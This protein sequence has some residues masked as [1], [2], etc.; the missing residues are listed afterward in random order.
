M[1]NAIIEHFYTSFI[2]KL[3]VI[4]QD[5]VWDKLNDLPS[6]I[7]TFNNIE[8]LKKA[9]LYVRH[10]DRLFGKHIA[11]LF[12]SLF[13][14][15][16]LNAKCAED[17]MGKCLF[18]KQLNSRFHFFPLEKLAGFPNVPWLKGIN[19]SVNSIKKEILDIY[20]V[21]IKEDKLGADYVLSLNRLI[22]DDCGDRFYTIEHFVKKMLGES[23]WIDICE[24]FESIQ[25][26]AEQY[27]WFELSTVCNYT[28][29]QYFENDVTQTMLEFDYG[30][31][32]QKTSLQMREDAFSIIGKNYF[33]GRYRFLVSYN[34]VKKS[35][36]TSEWL[37][38]NQAKDNDLDKTYIIAGYVKSV[39][40]LLYHV[41]SSLNPSHV[42]ALMNN[43]T[44]VQEMVPVNSDALFNATLGN[45]VYFLKDMQNRDIYIDG[46]DP[47]VI[48]CIISIINRWVYKER[49]G[50]FHKHLLC[51]MKKV[52][53]IR[54]RTY[55]LYYLILGSVRLEKKSDNSSK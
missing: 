55:L 27:Q 52:R 2:E 7:I 25:Y 24:A 39:E 10:T 21:L 29:M 13:E 14:E 35:L 49:N 18:V 26:A 43:K 11:N 41:I 44:K 53:Q 8:L 33:N 19:S 17:R 4:Y 1:T 6:P 38:Q 5:E 30:R 3:S 15:K 42:I 37:F 12:C 22:C 9:Q 50:Y 34:D 45:M 47:E 20:I 32:M 40:Q 23:Q 31:E 28:S 51:D 36:L 54:N 16:G 48:Q 46:I